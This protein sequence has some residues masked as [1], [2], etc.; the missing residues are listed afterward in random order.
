MFTD[1]E[2]EANEIFDFYKTA[3]PP[4][5]P[6]ILLGAL[7]TLTHL[8]V[9]EERYGCVHFYC[10]PTAPLHFCF[11]TNDVIDERDFSAEC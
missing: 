9:L 10:Q 7:P 5:P 2:K 8:S 3:K 11:S 1:F 6:L 4:L